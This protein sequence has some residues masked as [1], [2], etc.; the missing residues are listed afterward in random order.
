MFGI[1]NI[2]LFDK[3]TGSNG[4]KMIFTGRDKAQKPAIHQR[5]SISFFL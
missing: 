5:T 3:P 2:F 1:C 4:I